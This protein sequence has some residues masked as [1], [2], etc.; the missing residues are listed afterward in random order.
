MGLEEIFQL[1]NKQT[2]QM[3]LAQELNINLFYGKTLRLNF[4]AQS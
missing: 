3:R 1:H 4:Q 2:L